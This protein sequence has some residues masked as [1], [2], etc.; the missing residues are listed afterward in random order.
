MRPVLLFLI[1]VAATVSRAVHLDGLLSLPLA[2][3][4][5]VFMGLL[6]YHAVENPA[7]LFLNAR[8]GRKANRS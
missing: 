4:G 7:R 6:S 3:A 2:V 8:W 5:A 1:L